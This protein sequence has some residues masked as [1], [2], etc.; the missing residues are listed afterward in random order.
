[1]D[2][3]FHTKTDKSK[4]GT[5]RKEWRE[6]LA[7]DDAGLR[8]FAGTLAFGVA[9]DSLDNY[10]EQL[11]MLFAYVGLRRIPAHESA[12]P[13]DDVVYKLSLIHI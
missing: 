1:M 13:Y 3:L 6:H 12:F 5:V 9:T 10:R 7:L 2:R 4:A 11:D 8:Q